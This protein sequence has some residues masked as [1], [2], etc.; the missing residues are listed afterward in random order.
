MFNF[1]DR[2]LSHIKPYVYRDDDS[3]HSGTYTIDLFDI[4]FTPIE[5]M[6]IKQAI[7]AL[8]QISN[9]H[10]MPTYMFF[11]G[12]P[13]NVEYPTD[14]NTKNIQNIVDEYHLERKKLVSASNT[15]HLV[16]A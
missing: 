13:V 11:N 12:V 1:K 8:I 4:H 3:K 15:T 16:R 6:E 14:L 10:K 7:H 9:K 2:F 5:D